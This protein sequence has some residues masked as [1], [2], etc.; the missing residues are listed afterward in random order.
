MRRRAALMLPALILPTLAMPALAAPD[1]RRGFRELCYCESKNLAV[2][3]AAELQGYLRH[4]VRPLTVEALG[5]DE[6]LT[7]FIEAFRTG[8]AD[9]GTHPRRR[10]AKI[11]LGDHVI[12][13]N[14]G[15]L[16]RASL[17]S[18]VTSAILDAWEV[19]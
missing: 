3:I 9:C 1:W 4:P 11:I 8:L 16:I 7:E 18:A 14:D 5:W 15:G 12:S 19:L 2:P 6:S 17:P 10:E 13:D